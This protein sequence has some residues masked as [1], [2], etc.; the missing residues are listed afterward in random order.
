MS[1]PGTSYR[2]REEI[3][4]VREALDPITT[5]RQKII[6]ANLLTEEEL[7]V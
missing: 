1:D 2:N 4:E 3:Q 6:A 5:F 7:K